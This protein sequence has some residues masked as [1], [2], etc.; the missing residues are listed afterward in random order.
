[1]GRGQF[2]FLARPAGHA[3]LEADLA[4][5]T[6]T[7]HTGAKGQCAD[8]VEVGVAA[9]GPARIHTGTESESVGRANG[10]DRAAYVMPGWA[11][12]T[13]NLIQYFSGPETGPR[14]I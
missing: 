7:Q 9:D 3:P 10:G 11:G 14:S 5:D 1:M 6:W 2:S 13:A 8:A 12:R 4:L